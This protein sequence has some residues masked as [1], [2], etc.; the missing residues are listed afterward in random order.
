MNL[1]FS[2]NIYFEFRIFGFNKVLLF[3]VKLIVSLG[4][5]V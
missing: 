3:F 5:L 4:L 2:K 1:G